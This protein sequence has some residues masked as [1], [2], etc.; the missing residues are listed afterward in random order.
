M[1]V[2]ESPPVSHVLLQASFTILLVPLLVNKITFD[3][4]S[5]YFWMGMMFLPLLKL[6]S[7]NT[8]KTTF[9]FPFHTQADF[10]CHCEKMVAQFEKI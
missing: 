7:N 9:V 10:Q 4:R 6:Y 2:Y 3:V 8:N 5:L 1:P